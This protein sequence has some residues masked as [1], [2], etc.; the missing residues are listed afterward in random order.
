M[1]LRWF[2]TSTSS[3]LFYSARSREEQFIAVGIV[4]LD[5]VITPPRFLAGNRALDDLT[6]KLRNAILGQRYEQAPS[7]LA[8][9]GLVDN[10]LALG[11][12]DLADFAFAIV[13]VPRF[14]EAEHVYIKSKRAIYI[15][16][17]EHR[18]RVPLVRALLRFA[19]PSFLLAG[20]SDSL[21][22]VRRGNRVQRVP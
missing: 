12:I 21:A 1:T 15:G 9:G 5:H 20:G 2:V 8:V 4:D 17:E 19:L 13:C 6:A 18:A 16:N 14:L 22:P 7:V 11:A 10:Y 3:S